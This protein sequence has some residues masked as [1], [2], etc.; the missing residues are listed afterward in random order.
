MRGLKPLAAAA[1]LGLLAACASAPPSTRQRVDGA[2]LAVAR[3]GSGTPTVV[4]QSGLGDGLAAWAAVWQGLPASPSVFAYDRPGYGDSP[5]TTSPR[6]PCTVA[7]ELRTLLQ[8]AGLA[9]PYVL[10][11]HSLGGTYQAAF[12]RLFPQ[13]VAALLLL[14]ATHPEHWA[15]MQQRA[16]GMAAVVSTL[17]ATFGSAMRREFD[18]QA[19]CNARLAALPPPRVPSR[20]LVRTRFEMMESADFREM[21][22]ALQQ[23]WLADWPGL[24]RVAVEGSGHYIQKDRPEAVLQALQALLAEAAAARG[25]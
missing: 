12:A 25:R 13:D 8:A 7:T 20:L 11:G 6:D 21:S 19:A 2:E 22:V 1:V 4:F 14:D 10:V 16:P 23:R 5:A 18:D 3:H 24:Q 9:P 15:T 17:R